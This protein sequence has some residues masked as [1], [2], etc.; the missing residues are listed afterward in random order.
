MEIPAVSL[1]LAMSVALQTRPA[2]LSG[3]K[4][5][6]F[7]KKRERRQ[8]ENK[9]PQQHPNQTKKTNQNKKAQKQSRV[10]AARSPKP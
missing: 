2:K 5:K 10:P 7:T 1:E 8:K 6:G 3:M 4:W 9:K